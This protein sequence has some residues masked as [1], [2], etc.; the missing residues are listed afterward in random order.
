M[1]AKHSSVSRNQAR[2]NVF[3]V[4]EVSTVSFLSDLR[5]PWRFCLDTPYIQLVSWNVSEAD[6]A[7]DIYGEVSQPLNRSFV[8]IHRSW[9]HRFSSQTSIIFR[10]VTVVGAKPRVDRLSNSSLHDASTLIYLWLIDDVR[11]SLKPRFQA[12]DACERGPRTRIQLLICS[13]RIVWIETFRR[14]VAR[15]RWIHR[16]RL[17]NRP[18]DTITFSDLAVRLSESLSISDSLWIEF[19]SRVRSERVMMNGDLK[20]CW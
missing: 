10:R 9:S 11:V 17:L 19:D 6:C 18:L 12:I 7:F 15:A 20:G 8:S 1:A 14:S 2:S 13:R 16:W 4:I 5:Q 3:H